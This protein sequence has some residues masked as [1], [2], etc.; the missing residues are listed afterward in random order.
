MRYWATVDSDKKKGEVVIS[1]GTT[2]MPGCGDHSKLTGSSY[3]RVG[4]PVIMAREYSDLLVVGIVVLFLA[5]VVVLEAVE[6]CSDLRSTIC[7]NTR[8]R[9]H[10]GEIFLE[11][12]ESVACAVKKPFYLQPAPLSKYKTPL[13]PVQ[14]VGPE[15]EKEECYRD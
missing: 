14:E 9:Q 11:D 4:Q 2:R 8:R 13:T 15:S 5:A 1:D 12:E 6:Y 7:G 10:R 3:M